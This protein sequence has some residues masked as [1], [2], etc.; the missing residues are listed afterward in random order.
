M[1]RGNRRLL[2][3]LLSLCVCVSLLCLAPVRASAA[4]TV[5]IDRVLC[6]LNYPPVAMMDL[7]FVNISSS[8]TNC[9]INSAFWTD[10]AGSQVSGTFGTGNYTLNVTYTANAGCAFSPT[11]AGYI[12]NKADGVT[13][14]VSADGSTAT[15]RKTYEAEIWAPTAIKQPGSET[16]NMGGWTSFAVS[17]TYAES[18]EWFFESPDGAQKVAAADASAVWQGVTVSGADSERLVIHYVALGLD[19]WRVFCRHW[20]VNHVS[21]TDSSRATITITG[22]PTPAPTPEFTPIPMEAPTAEPLTPE[23]PAEEPLT[24]EEPAET[25]AAQEP[26]A[27]VTPAETPAPAP[28]ERSFS[29]SNDGQSHWRVYDDGESGSREDHLYVWHETRA[30]T[31]EQAGEETGVCSICGYAVTRPLAYEGSAVRSSLGIGEAL[32]IDG[33]SDLQ[34]LLIGGAAVCLLL[35][36]L[37]AALT[38]SRSRRSR[39]RRR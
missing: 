32:G 4:E 5:V 7:S 33:M 27:A 9:T 21:Y 16:V 10:G 13:V 24:P 6:S 34:L 38:P 19:G 30:A 29:Y 12:N 18:H 15:L 35:L 23:E 26:A 11:A 28:A 20:S 37:S 39:R 3:L 14:S 22:I 2:S 8:S 31:S 25:P 17:A 1:K 36:I